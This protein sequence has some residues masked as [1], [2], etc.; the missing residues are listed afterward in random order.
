MQKSIFKQGERF[1]AGDDNHF[2]HCR[3]RP[4][5]AAEAAREPAKFTT[6]CHLA[7]GWADRALP[8]ASGRS[9]NRTKKQGSFLVR[10]ASQLD[11]PLNDELLT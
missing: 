9:E 1:H 7:C 3:R 8:S 4:K 6:G 5:L 2:D 10:P 11:N